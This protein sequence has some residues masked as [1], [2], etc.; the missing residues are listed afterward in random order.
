MRAIALLVLL[1]IQDPD[2]DALLKQLEDDS[3]EVREKAATG[4][5][6]LGDKAEEKVKARMATAE[7][8]LKLFCKRILERMSVPKKL[9]GILPPLRKVTID[10]KDRSLKEVLEDLKG[11]T[12]MAM[13]SERLSDASVTLSFKDLLPMEALD[14][15]CKA[16]GLGYSID[17][18]GKYQRGIVPAGAPLRSTGDP[19]LSRIRFQ[20]GAY[21]EVPKQF[22]RHYLIEPTGI[23]L[24]KNS[25]FRGSNSNGSV[26]LRVLWPP[27]VKPQSGSISIV[28]V[29]DDKGRSLYEAPRMV[30]HRH[31]GMMGG[32]FYNGLQSGVQ[33]AYP[34]ADAK[35]IAQIKGTVTLKYVIEE[36]TLAFETPEGP[37]PHKK[38]HEGM[39][40]EITEYKP[41]DNVVQLKVMVSGGKL[42]KH[43]PSNPM[44]IEGMSV[45]PIRLK[46]ENGTFAAS[47][48]WGTSSDGASTTYNVSFH[49]LQSKVASVEVIVDTVYHT[50][51]LDFDLKNIPL[52]K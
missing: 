5:V 48:G 19:G 32:H 2:V 20:P 51:T 21:A 7:G 4:L 1:A 45:M 31:S 35:A 33:I 12:G 22:I 29:T 13:D 18:S 40:A 52:P 8:E 24:T 44:G 3:I 49:S 26:T 14:A 36:K 6:D 25:N 37:G 28:S 34:E 16:A 15:V 30:M 38:E 9:A 11:Q 39:T 42:G 50:D 10:A 27:E 43:D 23:S 46:L 47:G 17:S 41:G